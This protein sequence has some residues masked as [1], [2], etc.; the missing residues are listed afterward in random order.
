MD[1]SMIM[2]SVMICCADKLELIRLLLLFKYFSNGLFRI[3]RITRMIDN[4]ENAT[5]EIGSAQFDC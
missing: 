1:N 5:E 4:F 2:R 3:F